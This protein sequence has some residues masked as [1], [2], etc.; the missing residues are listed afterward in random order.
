MTNQQL[1]KRLR[2]SPV[3]RAQVGILL[4]ISESG[5]SRIL[6]GARPSP[7]RFLSRATAALNLLEQAHLACEE[8]RK[9]FH[10]KWPEISKRYE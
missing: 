9:R 3:S 10:A 6:S 1:N 2:E 4:G 8:V 7:V 5:M